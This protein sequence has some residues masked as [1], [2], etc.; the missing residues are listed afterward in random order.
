MVKTTQLFPIVSGEDFLD[1]DEV[2]SWNTPLFLMVKT[3]QLFPVKIFWMM[4]S[5]LM[6]HTI[7]FD[8]KNYPIVSGEDFLDDVKFSHGTH[9]YF[10]W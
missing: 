1:D 2:F 10:W 9:H 6:E 3:T 7:I 8:G 4:W 5:F